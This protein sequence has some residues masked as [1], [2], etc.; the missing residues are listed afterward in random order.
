MLGFLTSRWVTWTGGE[1][2][3]IIR[4]QT[5]CVYTNVSQIKLCSD[6]HKSV[7][8]DK[9]DPFFYSISNLSAFRVFFLL[10]WRLAFTIK[11][12]S[13]SSFI[14]NCFVELFQP[15]IYC[16]CCET[17]SMRL[18]QFWKFFIHW[19]ALAAVD[20]RDSGSASHC[21]CYLEAHFKTKLDLIFIF[22]FL[23]F[24]FYTKV[25]FFPLGM[26]WRLFKE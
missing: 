5:P 11:N 1:V 26:C 3:S 22:T 2:V 24:C 16:R 10:N 7:V 4:Y 15:L 17:Y 6:R 12:L 14:S 25:T 19:V 20:K 9:R 21:G 13:P 8:I 18:F 23:R